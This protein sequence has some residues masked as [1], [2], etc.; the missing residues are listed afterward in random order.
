M[1]APVLDIIMFC[2]PTSLQYALLNFCSHKMVCD[3]LTDIARIIF[4]CLPENF[5]CFLCV[6]VV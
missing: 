4:V 5:F 6:C 1:S 2:V 3:L